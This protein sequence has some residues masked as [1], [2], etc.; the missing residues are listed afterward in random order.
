LSRKTPFLFLLL[1][2]LAVV[3]LSGRDEGPEPGEAG[4]SRVGEQ[5]PDLHSVPGSH[6]G[7]VSSS[8]R[9]QEAESP[10]PTDTSYWPEAEQPRVHPGYSVDEIPENRIPDAVRERLARDY[11]GLDIAIARPP[12]D[13][14]GTVRR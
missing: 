6:H 13:G 3:I 4:N 11:V 2:M 8:W 1:A 7:L 5:S 10:V 9:A 12:Q 14:E